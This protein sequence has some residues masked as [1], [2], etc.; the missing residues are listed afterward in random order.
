MVSGALET[1]LD[2]AADCINGVPEGGV[3]PLEIFPLGPENA[4]R[5]SSLAA[6]NALASLEDSSE[7][8]EG[9]P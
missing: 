2:G 4:F 7:T 8:G 6:S 9:A 1:F 3:G 5:A